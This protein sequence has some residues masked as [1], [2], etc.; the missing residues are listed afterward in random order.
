MLGDDGARL[1]KRHGS[2]AL[3]DHREHSAAPE[4]IVG[5]L[6]GMFAIGDGSPAQLDDL[7]PFAAGLAG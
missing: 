1:A 4:D 5:M 7:V 3:R 2:I 6:A